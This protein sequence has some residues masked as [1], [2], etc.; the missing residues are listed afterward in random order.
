MTTAHTEEEVEVSR[1]DE[2]GEERPME[3]GT[4]GGFGREGVG[5]GGGMAGTTEGGMEGTEGVDR[6]GAGVTAANGVV[7][8]GCLGFG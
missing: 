6:M 5:R 3:G 4:T 2:D 1:E 7:K 8:G